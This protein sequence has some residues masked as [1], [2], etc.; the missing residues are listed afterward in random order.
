MKRI[1]TILALTALTFGAFAQNGK[2]A[3]YPKGSRV[4]VAY[5]SATGVTEAAAKQVAAVTGGDLYAITPADPYTATDL[6]WRDRQSRS[7]AEMRDASA[8]PQLADRDA[9]IEDYDVIYIGFPV[10]WNTAP[11]IINSFMEAYNFTGKRMIPF[12]TSGGDT[13]DGAVSGLSAAYPDI[14]WSEGLL[15]NNATA[16]SIRQRLE[17]YAW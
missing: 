13:V 17:Q 10:W 9:H 8:R 12:A 3:Q 6:N 5:F 1:T 11:R 15:L 16:D 4:L 7:S 14:K 2:T